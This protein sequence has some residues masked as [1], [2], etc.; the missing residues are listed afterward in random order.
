MV[1]DFKWKATD[2]GLRLCQR[3]I[4]KARQHVPKNLLVITR[5]GVSDKTNGERKAS[6][7]RLGVGLRPS[8][9]FQPR[10]VN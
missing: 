1:L 5:S 8:V 6:A 10:W 4:K 3:S 2:Y 7:Y 9:Y